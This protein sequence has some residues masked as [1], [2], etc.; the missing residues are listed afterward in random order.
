MTHTDF[1]NVSPS[2]D[3]DLLFPCRCL[4]EQIVP[5]CLEMFMQDLRRMELESFIFVD[6]FIDKRSTLS[7]LESNACGIFWTVSFAR[8]HNVLL[9]GRKVHIVTCSP[10]LSSA[11][12]SLQIC[13][14]N[15]EK[16]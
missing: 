3:I 5:C 4:L 6:S 1:M 7:S 13:L 15:F 10:D 11:R 2:R 8:V 12:A 14:C 16:L 9:V